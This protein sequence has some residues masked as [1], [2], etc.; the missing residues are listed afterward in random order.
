MGSGIDPDDVQTSSELGRALNVLRGDSSYAELEK[1]AKRLPPAGTKA[2][3]SSTLSDWF[4]GKSVPGRDSLVTFLTVRGLDEEAQRPWLAAWERAST[5]HLHRPAGAVQVRDARPRLLGV[6][7]AIRVDSADG[8]LPVYVPRDLD[9]DLRT[10]L[11]TVAEQGGVVLLV[12]GSSVGK[13]RALFEAVKAGVPEWWLIHPDPADTNALRTLAAQPTARTVVWLDE[14][15]RY[16]D[17]TDGLPV[18]LVRTLVA[19]GIALMGTLWPH[20]YNTRTAP[21]VPGQPDPHANDRQLLDLAHIID[22]AESFSST[23]RRRAKA[24]ASDRRIRVALDT[25]D[26]GFTQILAAGPDLVR[27]WEN[28]PAE[29][30]YGKAVITAALDA[31]RIGA[32][33]PLT[34]GILEA[35]APGYLTDRQQATAPADWLDQAL[36]YATTPLR[37]A[38]AALCPVAADMGRVAGYTVADYL[39]QH[40]RR[41]R[42][43]I[44]LPDTVWQAIADH[45]NPDDTLRLAEAARNRALVRQ[46]EVLYRAA[47]NSGEPK[48][49]TGLAALRMSQGRRREAFDL[50]REAGA[51]GD[52]DAW[53]RMIA[54]LDH[55]GNVDQALDVMRDAAAGGYEEA[56]GWSSSLLER[57]GRVA[58]A[59][60]A[61]REA[62]AAGNRDARVDL[63]DMLQELGRSDEAEQVW[64]QAIAANIEESRSGL[65]GLLKQQG[66]LDEAITA[67][68]NGLADGDDPYGWSALADLLERQGRIDETVDAWREAVHVGAD[69]NAWGRLSGLLHAHNRVDEARHLATTA[70]ESGD[71]QAAEVLASLFVGQGRI[72]QATAVWTERIAAGDPYARGHLA[73][74]LLGQQRSDEAEQV[75][76]EAVAVGDPFS[77]STPARLLEDHGRIEEAIDAWREAIDAGDP[78]AAYHVCKLLKEHKRVDEAEQIWREELAAGS[79][80]AQ[81]WLASLLEEEGRMSEAIALRVHGLMADG[82]SA[83]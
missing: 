24:L 59:E 76:R 50:W 30:C 19:A 69:I 32:T 6:H 23:E 49:L 78:N 7:A 39:H 65:A 21:P 64:Q 36:A 37:G 29:H 60:D 58:E 38:T 74:L 5:A 73:N 1:S 2:L 16:L 52:Q 17:T 14:L 27:H 67:L 80:T 54:V 13:T 75:L 4:T 68:Q 47:V 35:A 79:S 28:A 81:G 46:A 72:G 57:A 3:P 44:P 15:Q 20:E 40:A 66:R 48:G 45:H 26:A 77:C 12:G 33:A 71:W 83:E 18:A 62:I 53:R 25:P 55:E 11:T 8:E 63:A 22:A 61:L 82:S 70:F 10:A 42:R 41:T 43:A 51:A 56:L 9:A 34:R 31:R